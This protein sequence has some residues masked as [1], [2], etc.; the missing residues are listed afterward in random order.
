[1]RFVTAAALKRIAILLGIAAALLFGVWWFLLRM[2]GESHEGPPPPA[3][4]PQQSLAERLRADVTTLADDIGERNL[5]VPDALER[6]AQWIEG[7]LRAAGYAPRRHEYDVDGDTCANIEAERA[8]T[9]DGGI[10]VVGAHYDT[11]AGCPGANDNGSG[12]AATLALAR[13]FARRTPR[14]TVRFVLFVNEEP[15]NFQT[16]AMGSRVYAR[17][18]RERNE[19]IAAMFSLE[20]VGYFV[21]EPDSQRY[22]IEALKAAYPDRGNFIGFVGNVA[23]R[24]LVRRAL[25]TFRDGATV[26]SEGIAMLEAVPGVGWSD[27]WSFWQEGYPALMVTDTA[28]F[29][30]PEYHTARDT[31]D[32]LDYETLARVVEG[33]E[34]V[35]ADF[36]G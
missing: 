23:S 14:V 33:L 22:P 9:G 12:V 11:V 29:R 36:A 31:P 10:V 24:D 4:A 1:M 30:Y 7:S 25:K 17:R 35:I 3:T 34:R 8:G 5:F 18:C 15:P 21:D 13:A 16:E 20:T 32:L 6:A 2:P 19:E 27:H 28:P 26:P